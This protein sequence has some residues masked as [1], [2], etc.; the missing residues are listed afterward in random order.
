AAEMVTAA[1]DEISARIRGLREDLATSLRYRLL[2][3]RNRAQAAQS[4]RVFNA[5]HHRIRTTAQRFDD[6]VY[7]IETTLR[8]QISERRSR[9]PGISLRL[10]EAAIRRAAIV[11]RRKL[12]SLVGR[13]QATHRHATADRHRRLAILSGKLDSLSPLRVLHRGYAIAFDSQGHV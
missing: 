9:L 7:A 3:L 4:S 6:A 8:R 11:R 1:R 10:R 5:V 12:D 13:L 2:E